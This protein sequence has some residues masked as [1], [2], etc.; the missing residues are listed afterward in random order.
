MFYCKL[1]DTVYHY[2]YF[3]CTV[4][5]SPPVVEPSFVSE[6]PDSSAVV[7]VGDSPSRMT[8]EELL[9]SMDLADREI[10]EVEQQIGKLKRRLVN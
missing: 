8:K 2:L 10:T 6:M 7:K 1:T 5:C 3:V 4:S 9:H